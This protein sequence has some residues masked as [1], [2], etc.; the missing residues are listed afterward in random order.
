MSR[1]VMDWI[2]PKSFSLR[3][4]DF[5]FGAVGMETSGRLQLSS[6]IQTNSLLLPVTVRDDVLARGKSVADFLELCLTLNI[7]QALAI[8]V[9]TFFMFEIIGKMSKDTSLS[10]IARI[11]GQSPE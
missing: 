3:R 10:K 2:V 8:K 5:E 1:F 9:D 11:S 4:G 6:E 7:F